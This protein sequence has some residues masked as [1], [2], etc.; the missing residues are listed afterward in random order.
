MVDW[1]PEEGKPPGGGNIYIYIYIDYGEDERRNANLSEINDFYLLINA[2]VAGAQ[3][4]VIDA[5]DSLNVINMRCVCRKCVGQRKDIRWQGYHSS[6]S[7]LR[8]IVAGW[9][10]LLLYGRHKSALL[11]FSQI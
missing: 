5:C 9:T 11:K 4:N 10:P 8:A 1:Q 2:V 3:S 6:S 7:S